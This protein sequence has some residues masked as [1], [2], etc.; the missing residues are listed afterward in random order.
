M[1]KTYIT[2][3]VC[4][5][6][7]ASDIAKNRFIGLDGALPSAGDVVLGVSID[8]AAAGE[9][10]PV[11]MNGILIVEAAGSIT[12]GA[13]V[14]TDANGK[15]VAQASTAATVGYALEAASSGDLLKIKLV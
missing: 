5:V 4:S 14:S 9:G 10:L 3:L 6:K 8:S 7:A 15:C 12:A 13:A 11:A 1:G 2:N